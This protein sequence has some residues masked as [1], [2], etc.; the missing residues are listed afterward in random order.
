MIYMPESVNNENLKVS[1]VDTDRVKQLELMIKKY[2]SD[3]EQVNAQI[4]D[5][6]KQIK[7]KEAEIEKSSS[8]DDSKSPKVFTRKELKKLMEEREL[9]KEQKLLDLKNN[10]DAITRSEFEKARSVREEAKNCSEDQKNSLELSALEIEINAL[11][12]EQEVK[13]AILCEKRDKSQYVLADKISEE[14]KIQKLRKKLFQ[15]QSE[16]QDNGIIGKDIR[17]RMNTAVANKNRFIHDYEKLSK[18]INDIYSKLD[19]SKKM[20]KN[21]MIEAENLKK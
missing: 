2:D 10:I 13:N 3:L 1:L 18:E 20:L 8:G 12:K 9:A 21:K 11:E 16:K 14:L 6:E 7:E 4:E 15:L 5:L 17:S 19:R